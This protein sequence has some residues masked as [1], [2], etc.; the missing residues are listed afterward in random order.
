MCRA[1]QGEARD[2]RSTSTARAPRPVSLPTSPQVLW[3]A[4]RPPAPSS[5]RTTARPGTDRPEL[6]PTK[7]LK[8]GVH[9]YVSVC[10]PGVVRRSLSRWWLSGSGVVLGG[11]RVLFGGFG[12]FGVFF[13]RLFQ[14]VSQTTRS[15]TGACGPA[16][17]S[18][19]HVVWS[20]S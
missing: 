17:P 10:V 9:L 3:G 1:R 6:W 15:E 4:A 2:T 13:S 7:G 20:T 12:L 11:L 19:D 5:R 8:F 18:S 16:A 14:E